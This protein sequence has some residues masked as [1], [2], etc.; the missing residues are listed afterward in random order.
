MSAR[1]RRVE[2][3]EGF[4]ARLKG[5]VLSAGEQIVDVARALGVTTNDLDDV[6]KGSKHVRAA[7]IEL[8]PPRVEMLYLADR[9]R[10]HGMTL[11]AIPGDEETV[12]A[13]I[14]QV[15]QVLTLCGQA[16]QDGTITPDETRVCL[17]ALRM[18]HRKLGG[19]IALY[20][21]AECERGVTVTRG[22]KR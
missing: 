8:L 5:F 13:I 21:R 4:G 10:V 16:E 2:T 14:A 19:V 18:L 17:P 11:E 3:E 7:W 20:E 6:W 1:L 15:G 12:N 22:A 9:A